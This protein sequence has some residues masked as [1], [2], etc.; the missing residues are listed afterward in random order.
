MAVITRHKYTTALSNAGYL[1]QIGK[2]IVEP[3]LPTENKKKNK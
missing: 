1:R 2:K 3:T